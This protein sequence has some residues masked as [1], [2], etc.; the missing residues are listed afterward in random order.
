MAPDDGGSRL[1]ALRDH[2]ALRFALTG[3]VT[4]LVD[5]GCLRVL[6]G[7]LGVPLA[8]AAVISFGIAFLVNF[9]GSRH[10][11]FPDARDGR[12]RRQLLR[13]GLL[14]GLN[15]ASTL[16]IVVGLSSVGLNYLLAKVVAAAVNAVANFFA[17]R[18][19]VFTVPPVL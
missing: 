14:V 4:F 7:S 3:G 1:A 10:F 12:A 8:P 9:V 5:L 6:H 13:Y 17:Y 15:L 18:H 19:W 16:A 11:T 2:T